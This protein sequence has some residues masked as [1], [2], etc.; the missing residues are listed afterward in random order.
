[1]ICYLILFYFIVLT[2]TFSYLHFLFLWL[3]R[4]T[5][6]DKAVYLIHS[7]CGRY[8]PNNYSTPRP[9]CTLDLSPHPSPNTPTLEETLLYC[10]T[11]PTDAPSCHSP[12]WS[13]QQ[14]VRIMLLYLLFSSISPYLCNT[15]C[16]K[17]KIK[18]HNYVLTI[19][20]TTHG[21]C[22]WSRYPVFVRLTWPSTVLTLSCKWVWHSK[23]LILLVSSCSPVFINIE[24]PSSATILNV[25]TQFNFYNCKPSRYKQLQFPMVPTIWSIIQIKSSW[26]EPSPRVSSHGLPFWVC[27]LS[28]RKYIL[29]TTA[30][31]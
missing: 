27:V 3:N 13:D 1:M 11:Q 6:W 9:H 12:L 29:Y 22:L 7:K 31:L 23:E 18:L 14:T 21:M 17:H 24:L 19:T 20:T 8:A 4:P 15:S 16:P 30:V 26:S 5:R 10:L 25:A 28:R 2:N